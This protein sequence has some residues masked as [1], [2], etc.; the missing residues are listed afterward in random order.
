MKTYSWYNANKDY[1]SPDAIHQ[2]LA[3]GSLEDIINLRKLVSKEALK[4]AFLKYPKK[5]YRPAGFNFIKTFILGIKEQIPEN[6][7]LKD[8]PRH[9]G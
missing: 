3:F 4:E 6:K 8:A 9:I 5:V 7:Y 2:I 1:S